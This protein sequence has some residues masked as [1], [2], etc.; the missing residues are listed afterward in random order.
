MVL[1]VVALI[2]LGIG[3]SVVSDL[4]YESLV[5]SRENELKNQAY[6][7]SNHLI[8]QN[9]FSGDDRSS[10]DGQILQLALDLSGR[11]MVINQN[12]AVIKDTYN[13]DTGKTVA[14]SDVL[15]VYDTQKTQVKTD[16]TTH[17]MEVITPMKN[18]EGKTVGVLLVTTFTHSLDSSA[19]Q[20]KER[21]GIL[22][23]IL[24]LVIT[25]A[26][27]VAAIL[28]PRPIITLR[29]KVEHVSLRD[30]RFITGQSYRELNTMANSF[31][32]MMRRLEV[33]DESRQEFVSNVSH[34]LKTPITS[35]RILA[36]S[37]MS[38]EDIPIETYREFMSDISE[39]V[40]REAKIIDDLLTLVK[41]DKSK[42]ELNME[43]TD[44]NRMMTDLLRRIKPIAE[45]KNVEL[46]LESFRSVTA[47]VDATKL[48][49]ALS[50]LVENA[51]KYNRDGG[52]VHV[53]LN[54]DHKYFFVRIED[55]GIGIPEN[56]QEHIFDRF[57][58]VDK[59]RS[60]ETGGTGLGLAITK[61]IVEMH[62]GSIKVFS[63]LQEGTTFTVRIPLKYIA[64]GK[65]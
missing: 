50:N 7:M 39:E 55:S 40:D 27:V 24:G 48:S 49:L 16:T 3:F 8:S 35:M 59:A 37:L 19:K 54:A 21:M 32:E 31:N 51:I 29:Q 10:L 25:S 23:S 46:V 38:S 47:D 58:R 53:S 34:E 41:M 61:D 2:P 62:A 57:Y 63:Q 11:V 9:Y 52:Y 18:A 22:V 44:I 36:D 17:S 14:F 5:S 33:L 60:R 43:A 13:V 20:I 4:Y 30:K 28:I 1:L 26:A 45:K 64:A 12:L 15:S 42:V 6:V 56:A 65:A